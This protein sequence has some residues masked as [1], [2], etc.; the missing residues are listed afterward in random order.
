M[1]NKCLVRA[2]GREIVDL[3]IKIDNLFKKVDGDQSLLN[4]AEMIRLL[5]K[6]GEKVDKY[7]K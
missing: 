4:D 2:R 3:S 6:L 7:R 5:D 1:C